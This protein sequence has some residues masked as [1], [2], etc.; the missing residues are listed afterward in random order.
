MKY[1]VNEQGIQAMN[2]M[3]SA[4]TESVEALQG[5][6]SNVRSTADGYQDTLGPHK[7]SLETALSEIE[8]DLRQASEPANSIAET[9]KEVAEAYEEIIGND[10][11]KSLA[12]K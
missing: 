4:V 3:A 9:L 5:L 11:I 7:E 10:R 2:K 12:G 1:A 6:T 8:Q